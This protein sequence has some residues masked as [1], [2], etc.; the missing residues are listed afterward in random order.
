MKNVIVFYE[1][2]YEKY[3]KSTESLCCVI[4]SVT[5][6]NI[7]RKNRYSHDNK[8]QDRI[9]VKKGSYGSSDKSIPTVKENFETIKT[10]YKYFN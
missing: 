4:N 9:Y 7:D 8:M 6:D 2:R 1:I 3:R 5:N 10:K